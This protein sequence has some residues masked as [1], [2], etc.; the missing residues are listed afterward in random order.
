MNQAAF[1]Q[2]GITPACGVVFDCDG[3][4]AN[5]TACWEETFSA[6]ASQFGLALGHDQL[7]RL[8][9]AALVSAARRMV[10][11]SPRSLAVGDVL[12]ALRQQLV[13]SIDASE[14]ILIEGV[15]ELLTELHAIV[16]LAVASNSPRVVLLR[17]LARLELTHYF[18]AAISADDVEQPKPAPDPYL[19]ACEALS[20]DPRLSFAVEDSQ[21]GIRSAVA[22]GLAVIE[23]AE[24]SAVSPG[25][26]WASGSALQVSS[27]ADRRVRLLILGQA[28]RRGRLS[29]E[30]Y[31]PN[32]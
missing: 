14:L 23:L 29:S 7:A 12:D 16:P 4:L 6:V 17:T 9:G 28:A 27:L 26:T 10:R 31:S 24:S 8:R 22:A 19:A 2:A 15:R 11:W 25:R 18:A 20:V 21:V 5:T 30:S 32:L 3:V 13:R 1:R